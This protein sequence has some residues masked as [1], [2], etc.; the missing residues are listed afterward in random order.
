MKKIT[1]L[2]VTLLSISLNSFAILGQKAPEIQASTWINSDKISIN[3]LKGKVVVIDFFQLWCPMCNSFVKPLLKHWH[4][5]YATQIKNGDLVIMGVHT[6]FEGHSI[7]NLEALKFYL[8]K[9]N[10]THPIANDLLISGHLPETMKKYRTRGTPEVAIIDKQG[11]IRFQ[12]FG[13]FQPKVAENLIN[14]LLKQ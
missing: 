12:N 1:I 13:S 9:N 14:N 11:I 10:I 8:K 5:K 2:L 7:Q 3:D 6:V 4:K